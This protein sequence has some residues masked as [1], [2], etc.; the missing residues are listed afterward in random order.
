MM[1][2]DASVYPMDVS[3]AR[4]TCGRVTPVKMNNYLQW[5]FSQH[6]A[7][8]AIVVANNNILVDIAVVNL[9]WLRGYIHRISAFVRVED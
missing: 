5:D 1:I 9:L 4:R 2:M 3:I 6:G 8:L 7:I